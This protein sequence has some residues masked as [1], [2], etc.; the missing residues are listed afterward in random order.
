MDPS[1][2]I[3]KIDSADE[4]SGALTKS[5]KL[6]VWGKNDR[7]Q[8]GTGEGIGIDMTESEK[9]PLLVKNLNNINIVDFSCGENTMLIK[10]SQGLLYKTGLKIDY[11]PSLIEITKEI[12]PKL[13]LC[14]N[15][16][17]SKEKSRSKVCYYD[18][19]QNEKNFAIHQKSSEAHL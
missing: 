11:T 18:F 17:Y 1:N 3:V 4:F 7:G 6:Y 5:G 2:E 19:K 13:F 10:D 8:L 9:Y 15:S 16:Y 12:K 14:G